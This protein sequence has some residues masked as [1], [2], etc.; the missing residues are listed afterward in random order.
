MSLLEALA[1]D[2]LTISAAVPLT[3]HA[4]RGK[5]PPVNEWIYCFFMHSPDSTVDRYPV[6]VNERSCPMAASRPGQSVFRGI[7]SHVAVIRSFL[8][9]G[10]SVHIPWLTCSQHFAFETVPICA[11]PQSRAAA[12]IYHSRR[13][14]IGWMVGY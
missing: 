11:C 14:Y 1:D 12:H 2:E 7:T 10:A 8:A 9:G 4:D 13:A 5:L 3:G 6:T